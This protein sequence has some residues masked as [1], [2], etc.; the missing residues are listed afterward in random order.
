MIVDCD[1]NRFEKNKVRIFI[2]WKYDAYFVSNAPYTMFFCIISTF[3]TALACPYCT[4]FYRTGFVAQIVLEF[5]SCVALAKSWY[6]QGW[7]L[8][9]NTSKSYRSANKILAFLYAVF[10]NDILKPT[11]HKRRNVK[12]KKENGGKEYLKHTWRILGLPFS[13]RTAFCPWYLL[14]AVSEIA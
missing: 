3:C 13:R 2:Y 5:A 14:V 11:K 10:S 7:L 9:H 1:C 4:S 6:L 12:C 8:H